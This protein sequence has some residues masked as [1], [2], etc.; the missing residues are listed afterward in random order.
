MD[1]FK[2]PPVSKELLAE[3]E[4]R[5]PDRLPDFVQEPLD[6]IRHKQGQVSVIR[7]LRTQFELQN[8]NILEN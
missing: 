4:R 3:L 8:R 1:N 5:F 7:F 2:F 6:N